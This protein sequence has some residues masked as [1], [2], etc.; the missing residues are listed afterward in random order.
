MDVAPRIHRGEHAFSRTVNF[1]QHR[2]AL[3]GSAGSGRQEPNKHKYMMMPAGL[4]APSVDSEAVGP[5]VRQDISSHYFFFAK[6]S[7]TV[8]VQLPQRAPNLSY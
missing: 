1:I 6:S 3:S 7:T 5:P 4:L 8:V 2:A